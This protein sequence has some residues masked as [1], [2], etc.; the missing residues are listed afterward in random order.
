MLGCM[1]T[2]PIYEMSD[3]GY[4]RAV[5][6]SH[7][8]ATLVSAPGGDLAVSH[9]PVVP[10]PRASGATVLGHLARQD[11]EAHELGAH[12]VV[13]IVQ[14]PH[15]YVS[16]RMYAAGP[17]VPTWN[18]VVAH[19]HGRPEVLNVPDTYELLSAT[20]DHFEAGRPDPFALA[21][22]AEYARS[23][24]AGVTGFRLAPSRVVGK[25]KASQDKPTEVAER[26][27]RALR[28][29]NPGLAEVMTAANLGNIAK[30]D[31]IAKLALNSTEFHK[32]AARPAEHGRIVWRRWRGSR[33]QS[34]RDHGAIVPPAALPAA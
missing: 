6:A 22:V 10:D 21:E 30:Q 32:G 12:E 7:G 11:A 13:L 9:L 19:L 2:Q 27:I 34:G 29:E 28:T 33:R 26:V 31:G 17:Y 3:P 5:I 23:I 1:L 8:W 20:V 18:F 16:P 4:L 15:G 24:A 14:G 25:V